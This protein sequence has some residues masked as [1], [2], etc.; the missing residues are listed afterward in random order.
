MKRPEWIEYFFMGAEVVSFRSSCLRRKIGAVA[1]QDKRVVC[2]GYNGAPP[3]I[4]SCIEI[5]SCLRE[6]LKVQSGERHELCRAI[7]AEENLMVQAAKHGIIL[8]GCDV[9]CTTQPC[10]IC[11]KKLIGIGVKNLY[12]KE[13]YPDKMAEELLKECFY[14]DIKDTLKDYYH[15]ISKN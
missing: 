1:V 13:S 6:E 5:G 14:E 15:W 3:G 9:Y 12:Y 2:T 7:H 11:L 4:K 10:S 8:K